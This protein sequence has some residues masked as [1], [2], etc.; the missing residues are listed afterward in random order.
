MQAMAKPDKSR[1]RSQNLAGTQPAPQQ[2]E[3]KGLRSNAGREGRGLAEE[4]LRGLA[5]E[6]RRSTGR[7]KGHKA[8][9][10]QPNC[11]ELWKAPE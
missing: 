9:K 4:M 10:P 1:A 6:A 11:A 8:G 7:T 3:L 5:G 2:P